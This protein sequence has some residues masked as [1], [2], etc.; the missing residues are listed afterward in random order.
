MTKLRFEE[1][2]TD[3]SKFVHLKN[4][5][6]LMCKSKDDMTV[7]AAEYVTSKYV[8]LAFGLF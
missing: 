4:V 3:L 5:A 2:L 8:S 6:Y 1:V 7:K